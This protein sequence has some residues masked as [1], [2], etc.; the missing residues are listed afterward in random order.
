[1]KEYI[2]IL[3]VFIFVAGF[4]VTNIVLSHLVGKR[5][6]TRAKLMP[7]ECGMDP[8]GS[9][10]QRFS[11]KFYLIAMLFILFDIEAV[12]LLPWAVVFKTLSQSFS[13]PFIFFEMMIFIAVLLVGYVYVWKKGLFDWNR[14]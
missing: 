7:Y 3:I 14:N 1:M 4:A 12:F 8:V 2:P 11:V 6:N 10:H 9:A 13:R 5:K